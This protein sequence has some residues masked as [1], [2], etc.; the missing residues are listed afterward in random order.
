MTWQE[1]DVTVN[2]IIENAFLNKKKTVKIDEERIVDL[3]N[4]L[5]KRIDNSN[6]NRYVK[7]IGSMPV[8]SLLV[9]VN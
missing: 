3:E 9:M 5:Q 6:R 4:M 2:T 8:N 1:Y 7:R